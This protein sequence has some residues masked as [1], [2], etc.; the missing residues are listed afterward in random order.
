MYVR[1][2]IFANPVNISNTVV[3]LMCSYTLLKMPCF[4]NVTMIDDTSYDKRSVGKGQSRENNLVNVQSLIFNYL[5][6]PSHQIS[7]A[8]K[9]YG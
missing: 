5:K 1:C 8:Q 4:F 7:Y 6:R 9:W 3:Y 2:N